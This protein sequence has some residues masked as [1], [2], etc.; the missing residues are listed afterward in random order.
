MTR[1][2]AVAL[3]IA[4]LAIPYAASADAPAAQG[5]TAYG[6]GEAVQSQTALATKSMARVTM[7]AYDNNPGFTP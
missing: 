5:F 1:Y 7:V 4:G 6:P 3:V 2:I